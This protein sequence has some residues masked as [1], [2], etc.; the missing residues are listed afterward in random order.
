MRKDYNKTPQELVVDFWDKFF[1]KKPGKITRIFPRSLYATL[2]QPSQPSGASSVRNAADSYETAANECRE[3]VKRIVRECNRTNEKFT[4]PDFDIEF[5]MDRARNCLYGLIRPEPP[6]GRDRLRD[7]RSSSSSSSSSASGDDD[8]GQSTYSPMSV[9]RVDWIFE[10][11]Q[12]TKDGYSSSDIKQGGLG[13]CWWL[14]AVA[15]IANRRDLMTKICVA[16]DEDVGVYGFVFH[17]D[18]EWVS[19]VVDD[20]LYLHTPDFDRNVMV[21]VYDPSGRKARDHRRLYQTG[22]KALYFSKCDDKDETWLPLLE[23]AFAK[24]HGDFDAISGGFAGE[25]VEDLTGGVSTTVFPNRLLRKDRFWK[26]LVNADGDFVF[27][28]GVDPTMEREKSGLTLGHAYSILKATE[29]VDEEGN[30]VRLVQIRNPYGEHAWDGTGEWTGPWSD[31][32]KE[33][34]AY[35]LRK[36][37]HSFGDDGVFWMSFQDMLDN[38]QRIHRTRLF[39]DKWTIVQQWA[40]VN[41]GWVAGYLNTKFIIDVKKAGTVVIVLSQLDSRY[42]KGLEGQYIFALHF[43]LQEVGG[44]GDHICRVRPADDRQ[45][46][47]VSCEIDLEPGRYEVLP[48]VTARRFLSKSTVEDVVKD[49]AGI[50]SDKLR[51]VGMLYDLAHS[52]G[53]IIDEDEV[54]LQKR[55][56]KKKKAQ[57]REKKRRERAKRNRQRFPT[58]GRFEGRITM[59]GPPR[60]SRTAAAASSSTTSTST[61]A[62]DDGKDEDEDDKFEDAVAEKASKTEVTATKDNSKKKNDDEKK[63]DNTSAVATGDPVKRESGKKDVGGAAAAPK[64]DEENVVVEDKKETEEEKEEEE[65]KAEVET[66]MS[67]SESSEGE[68]SDS[69]EDDRHSDDYIRYEDGQVPWNAVC[70]LGL[71]VY[72]KDPEVTVSLAEPKNAEEGASLVVD[73]EPVGATM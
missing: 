25:G 61:E 42:F 68:G 30:R 37:N 33:W 59:G 44:N 27:S 66:T 57:E 48:K 51:Q 58:T 18:G 39:D 47:S 7:D 46:R 41:V 60:R 20:N 2:L 49:L 5:G 13:D 14:A 45:E 63:K 4:D 16:R 64:K 8:E 35:W 56:E 34:T 52:K 24:V 29:E 6:L 71:R 22:S 10:S 73:S 3:K 12:F 72:A 26:E 31:G 23:K 69:E 11:P 1:V 67:D 50:N 28:C 65:R 40:S 15:T 38:F 55:E 32:S 62:G 70:V 17:R 21:A 54:L 36:L 9:H 53:G 19:V 43:M